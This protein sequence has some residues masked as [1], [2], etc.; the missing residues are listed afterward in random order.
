MREHR[1]APNAP[2]LHE[3][4]PPPSV[5]QPSEGLRAPSSA[6]FYSF[7]TLLQGTAAA[8][9]TTTATAAGFGLIGLSCSKWWFYR[10]RVSLR[11]HLAHPLGDNGRLFRWNITVA[12][13]ATS[14]GVAGFSLIGLFGVSM[15]LYLGRLLVG[16]LAALVGGG[17]AGHSDDPLPARV[18]GNTLIVYPVCF[19][20]GRAGVML[21][22]YL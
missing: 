6:T 15:N 19:L 1:I 20:I 4:A 13:V 14:T 21:I 12:A 5:A 9:A 7:T 8:A 17:M 22:G 3:F 18:W 11:A 16:W 2:T 10:H